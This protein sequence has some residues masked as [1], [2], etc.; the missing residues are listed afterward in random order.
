MKANR[1]ARWSLAVVTLGSLAAWFSWNHWSDGTPPSCHVSAEPDAT[2]AADDPA[3]AAESEKPVIKPSVDFT[4]SWQLDSEASDSLDEILKAIGLSIF[5]RTLVNNTVVT[6][7]IQQ[8]D[9][10]FVIEIKTSF[11]GRTD[12][13]PTNGQLAETTDPGGRA[14]ESTSRWSDDGERLISKIN[15]VK[16]KQRFTLTRSMD[17]ANDRMDVLIEFFAADGKTMSA[18]RIYRR[19]AAESASKS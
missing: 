6:H 4:G 17:K 18:R 8:T 11:F 12:R 15:V 14:V 19:V 1:A 5:E 10:E 16:D 3:A 13:L 7:V 2:E 9:D